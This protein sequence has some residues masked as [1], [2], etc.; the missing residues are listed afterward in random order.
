M[1][2]RG[3]YARLAFLP[4]GAVVARVPP[5]STESLRRPISTE[6]LK[7]GLQQL[8]NGRAPDDSGL[9]P[10]ISPFW[11]WTLPSTARIV[12]GGGGG[13]KSSTTPMLICC[14]SFI[15]RRTMWQTCPT[16][17][18]IVQVWAAVTVAQSADEGAR[19]ACRSNARGESLAGTTAQMRADSEPAQCRHAGAGGLLAVSRW[20]G[21]ETSRGPLAPC[22][23]ALAG[24]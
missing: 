20:G 21:E 17:G 18:R 13:Y 6:D 19:R 9:P 23:R 22:N 11:T 16:G 10:S 24:R 4:S 15:V 12:R 7:Y 8:P 14:R 5:D 2:D 1:V 3:D